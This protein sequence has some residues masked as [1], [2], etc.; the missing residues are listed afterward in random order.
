MYCISASRWWGAADTCTGIRP[1]VIPTLILVVMPSVIQAQQP[2]GKSGGIGHSFRK[3]VGRL[4]S[5]SSERK[6]EKKKQ[7]SERE[8]HD[9]MNGDHSKN[10]R[11]DMPLQRYYLGEDPFGGSIYGRE[12]EYRGAHPPPRRPSR[13]GDHSDDSNR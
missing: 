9:N 13:R 5:S 8:N 10:H 7:A 4:R 6:K 11:T 1:I 12:K 3:L 2:S